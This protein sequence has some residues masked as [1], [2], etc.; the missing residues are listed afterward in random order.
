EQVADVFV[1]INSEG[2][3][4]NQSDFILTLMSVFW[5]EGRT[6]LED[7]S[8][9]TR[10]PPASLGKASAYNQIFQPEPDSLLRVGV[11]IAFR[12]GRLQHIYS[13]LR[14]KDLQTGRFSEA[15]RDQQFNRLNAAQAR[16][17]DPT[18]WADYLN[19]V[20]VAGSRNARYVS[21]SMA[22][23]FGYQLY[24]IGRTEY[25]VEPRAL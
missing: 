8:I 6:A 14:G 23:V 5:D 21:S 2:K 22:L 13:L 16:V 25:G 1:R 18:H 10:R 9:E 3:K 24:L 17:I 19:V 11:G 7:F 12:R 20:R 4:L 15:M